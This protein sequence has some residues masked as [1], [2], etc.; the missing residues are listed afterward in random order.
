[1]TEYD[2]ITPDY[3]LEEIRRIAERVRT[4]R[5]HLSA[6]DN[7]HIITCMGIAFH[8]LPQDKWADLAKLLYAVGYEAGYEEASQG[9]PPLGDAFDDYVNGLS[10]PEN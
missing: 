6:F 5:A 7:A 4:T 3:V 2:G 1:M 8:I 10:F 9:D